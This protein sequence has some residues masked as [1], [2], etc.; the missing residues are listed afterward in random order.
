MKV[1]IASRAQMLDSIPHGL[2]RNQKVRDEVLDKYHWE[3]G[4]IL[5]IAQKAEAHGHEVSIYFGKFPEGDQIAFFEVRATDMPIQGTFNWHLQD[6][7]QWMYSG[8]IQV[9]KEGQVSSHH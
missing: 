1:S 6:T 8:C 2:S 9:T 3:L 4:T 5:D 7:S